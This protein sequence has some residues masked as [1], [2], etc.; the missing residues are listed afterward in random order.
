MGFCTKAR[1]DARGKERREAGEC[2][3]GAELFWKRADRN[4]WE[5]RKRRPVWRGKKKRE[6]SGPRKGEK[7]RRKLLALQRK[8]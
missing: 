7:K 1:P 4:S 8:S 3:L 5:K 6:P 2:P